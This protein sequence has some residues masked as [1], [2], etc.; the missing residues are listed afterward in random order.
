MKSASSVALGPAARLE[1][2]ADRDYGKETLV[3]GP[4]SRVPELGRRVSS[5]KLTCVG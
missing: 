3:L 2:F 5:F 4:G 1:G